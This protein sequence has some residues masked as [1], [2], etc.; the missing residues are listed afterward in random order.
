MS[1]RK[2]FDQDKALRA[3]MTLFRNHGYAGSSMADIEK[4]TGLKKSSIYN[5]FGNKEALYGQ[6]LELFRTKYTA[7]ALKALEHKD[8]K[9]AF[10]DLFDMF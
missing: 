3:A 7:V 2:Q 5:C 10:F 4:A 9:H 1:G 8:V 6:A